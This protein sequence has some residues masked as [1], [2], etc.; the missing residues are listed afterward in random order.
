MTY[1]IR[2]PQVPGLSHKKRCWKQA[3]H[4]LPHDERAQLRQK[5]NND[6]KAY[7]AAFRLDG[8]DQEAM[9]FL[10]M[11]AF[12]RFETQLL[13]SLQSRHYE[14]R[15]Q[16]ACADTIH[17]I[18]RN[19]RLPDVVFIA[20]D[21]EGD[22]HD[23]KG[24][25]ELGLA[26]LDMQH[27]EQGIRGSNIA[28]AGRKRRNYLFDNY[29]RID[30]AQLPKTIAESLSG[31]E[32]IVLVGHGI[33]AELL[34][35]KKL[36]VPVEDLKSVVGM[37]DTTRLAREVSSRELSLQNVMNAVSIPYER[38]TFHC[39]GN[40]AFYTMQVFLALLIRR[41]EEEMPDDGGFE[42]SVY[43]TLR[44]M[45]W[46]AAPLKRDVRRMMDES[47]EEEEFGGFGGLFGEES[48]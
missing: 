1:Q 25:T 34:W 30:I 32:Q 6:K 20:I 31:D 43:A 3:W 44:E 4:T 26:R 18:V 37:I 16:L 24:V 41:A 28:T 5:Y 15:A 10:G 11:A 40:D 9:F 36:G 2:Q 8:T 38:N 14:Q 27:L 19:Y 35:M 39:G 42:G 21:F 7:L 48:G 23:G 17:S 33:A 12:V 47:R 22:V 46:R 45:A 29:M 13:R